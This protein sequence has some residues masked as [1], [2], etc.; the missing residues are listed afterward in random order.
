MI[1]RR[2]ECFLAAIVGLFALANCA[3]K[4]AADPSL[5][6]GLP[7]YKCSPRAGHEQGGSTQC[8]DPEQILGRDE[9]PSGFVCCADGSINRVEAVEAPSLD[10]FDECASDEDCGN[11]K[12]CLIGQLVNVRAYNVCVD[13][14]CHFDAECETGECGLAQTVDSG[15]SK[16]RRLACRTPQDS[17]RD[18]SECTSSFC[19]A[20]EETW[21][22]WHDEECITG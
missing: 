12:A 10:G 6:T 17:C 4:E 8:Q 1:Q 11:G 5:G 13:A 15:C 16:V 21:I 19:F 3:A 9:K 20:L 18:D 22:C 7:F 14:T 2:I